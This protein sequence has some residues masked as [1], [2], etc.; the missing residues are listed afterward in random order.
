MVEIF[1][2]GNSS[3]FMGKKKYSNI[4]V[5]YIGRAVCYRFYKQNAAKMKQKRFLF[6]A[7]KKPQTCFSLVS[8]FCT[9]CGL[10]EDSKKVSLLSK[11]NFPA[12]NI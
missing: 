7:E 9:N 5:S 11:T 1:D 6:E 3:S 2:S 8:L 10:T 4:N 12:E